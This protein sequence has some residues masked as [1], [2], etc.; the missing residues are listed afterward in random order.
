M[1]VEASS[2]KLQ[3]IISSFF[4]FFS[5]VL[6]FTF[7]KVLCFIYFQSSSSK[8][9]N[10]RI[11]LHN[12]SSKSKLLTYLMSWLCS[13]FATICGF[14]RLFSTIVIFD[15][16]QAKLIFGCV[17]GDGGCGDGNHGHN[18]GGHH[19]VVHCYFP[20]LVALCGIGH[21]FL[22]LVFVEFFCYYFHGHS[23]VL[24]FP[25]GISHVLLLLIFVAFVA[26]FC[27]YSLW[28]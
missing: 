10:L 16:N 14:S 26:L 23:H 15:L 9:Q 24:C 6:H 5:K 12:S 21:T 11:K 22:L 1:F 2:F 13:S 28:T 19:C 4:E 3:N 7:Q 27:C 18:N 8:V 25:F 17:Y 20:S